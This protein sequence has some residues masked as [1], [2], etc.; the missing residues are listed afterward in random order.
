MSRSPSAF[1]IQS[2]AIWRGFV[3]I[4]VLAGWAAGGFTTQRQLAKSAD[5]SGGKGDANPTP[6]SIPTAIANNK[7]G[8]TELKWSFGG[9]AQRGWGIYIP[10]ILEA[11]GTGKD[12]ESAEF[13]KAVARWQTDRGL[14]ATGAVDLETWSGM[15]RQFQSRRL[16]ERNSPPSENL[17]VVPASEFYDDER[18][19]EFRQ[20]ERAAYAAYK[21]LVAGAARDP[22]LRLSVTR[23]GELDPAEKYLKIISGFR[24]R[25]Y[26]DR[27]RQAAPKAGRAE[28][29][30]N[31]PHF[32]GRALDLYVGGEPVDTKDGNR[33]VQTQTA[34][35]RWL[36]K[37]A[38][39]FGFYPYFYEPWHWEYVPGPR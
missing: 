25:E 26:Q 6:W 31:S 27:L 29:A 35:Y 22:S 37:N 32:T 39:K 9:K 36:V 15:I 38:G 16:M 23:S 14:R 13:A 21:R 34:V 8:R 4:I 5:P 10:L 20:V 7:T 30:I 19:A 3:A 18:P 24:S 11:V 33:M 2:T 12:V 17:V 28:L 1:K